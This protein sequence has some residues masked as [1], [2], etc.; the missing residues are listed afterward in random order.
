VVP[1][2]LNLQGSVLYGSGIG[3]YGSG[4]LADAVIGSTGNLQPVTA[5]HF[6]VGAIAHPFPGNDLYFYY[7][8]EQTQANAWTT[9]TGA[10][11]IQGGWGNGNFAE[12]CGFTPPAASSGAFAFNGSAANCAANVQRIQEFTVGFWQDIY[13]GDLGRARVGV[14]YEY[15]TQHLFS[16]ATTAAAL[17]GAPA[18]FANTGL[19][20]NNNIVFFSLRYYPFN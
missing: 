9:G 8:Q 13:K 3:T 16:G 15:V 10:A 19:N 2:S 5:L 17:G 11:A 7:G 14:Q 4:Q 20:P 1:T 12:A 18:S 6:L